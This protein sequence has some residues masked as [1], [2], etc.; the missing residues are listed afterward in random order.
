MCISIVNKF[1]EFGFFIV[2]LL[3]KNSSKDFHFVIKIVTFNVFIALLNF[4]D[5]IYMV[6]KF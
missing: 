4:G 2:V 6:V 1:S 3:L 5:I